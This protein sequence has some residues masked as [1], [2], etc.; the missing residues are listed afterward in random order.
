MKNNNWIIESEPFSKRQSNLFKGLGILL[1]VLHNFFHNL[2]PVIGE[3]EFYFLSQT[4]FT[5]YNTIN[6]EPSETIRAIMSYFGHYGVHI[7]VFFST[8]GLTRKYFNN[9]LIYSHFIKERINKIYFSFLLCVLV[10]VSLGLMKSIFLPN[11]KIIYWDSLIWKILLVSDFI[12]KQALMP[13]GPWWFIPFIFQ[14]YVLYPLLLKGFQKY[15]NTFLFILV[16]IFILSE[17]LFNSYLISID[18]NINYAPFGHMPVICLGIAYGTHKR[19]KIRIEHAFF[20]LV[21]FILGNFSEIA[22][23]FSGLSFMIIVLSVFIILS[24]IVK[25]FLIENIL[26]FFGNISFYLFMVNGFLRS[27]FHKIAESYNYWWMDNLLALV[28]L[29][30]ST[31]FAL[32]LKKIDTQIR[33]KIKE[34]NN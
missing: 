26:I 20:A 15:K 33:Q 8:Y 5:F 27:P 29:L 7:F 21:V 9:N 25:C 32:G 22:W 1:I 4:F 31:L 6:N 28:S 12:P 14:V 16:L 19:I 3:N 17:W 18:V 2:T 34:F 30:F 10:Y 24:S 23:L 13:V 11:E